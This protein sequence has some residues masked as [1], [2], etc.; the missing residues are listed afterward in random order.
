MERPQQGNA[1]GPHAKA[2]SPHHPR[3]FSQKAR[4]PRVRKRP[5]APGPDLARLLEVVLA[6]S[7]GDFSVRL[8]VERNGTF[9]ALATAVNELISRNEGLTHELL[10]I[11]K[12]VGREGSVEERASLQFGEG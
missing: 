10:R 6:A 12:V 7:N 9:G 8:P 11:S 1:R 2:S 3:K 4:A 5:A